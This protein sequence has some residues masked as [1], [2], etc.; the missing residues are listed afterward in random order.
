[1]HVKAFRVSNFRR[2][3]DVRVDLEADTSIFVGANNSGK[4]SAT[5][6]FQLFLGESKGSFSIYDFTADCWELFDSCDVDA[7]VDE[8]GLPVITFDLWFEVDE[9]NFHRVVDLLPSL[10]WDGS[11]V[12]V[13]MCY[14]PKDSSKLLQN[15]A[16][17]RNRAQL[18]DGD[19]GAYRPWP[20]TLT[21]YLSKRLRSE[22]EII[23]AVLDSA[24][25]GSDLKPA[26]GCQPF[27]LSNGA[28]VVDSL[29][30]VDFLDAQRHLSDAESRGRY[31]DLSKRLSRFYARNLS[32]HE[33]D[34]D[35]LRTLAESEMRLNAHFADVFDPLLASLAQLGYPGF[36]NHKLVVKAEINPG[37]VLSGN[38]HVH[39]ALPG[40]T[41]SKNADSGPTLPDQYNG[42][43]FKNLIYMVVEVLDFHHAWAGADGERPPVHLVMIEEPEA[44]LHAQLQ[45]VFIR[46]IQDVL[47]AA[48]DGFTTQMVV[49]THSAH[50]IYE[51]DFTP[52]R[53]FR[54]SIDASANHISDVRN[55][56][57]FYD[58]EEEATRDF[59][60]Q[61]LKLTHC[62]L[63]FADAA[64]LVEGNV[65]RLLLPLMIQKSRP[66]L[67][68]CHLTILEVGGAFAHKFQQLLS[69]LDLPTLIIT[70]L[71]SVESAEASDGDEDAATEDDVDDTVAAAGEAC[72]ADV[73]G[74]RTSNETL[75]QWVP[76]LQSVSELLAA[77]EKAKLA[78]DDQGQMG[79]VRVAY[80]TLQPASWGGVTE[81]V[82]GRTLEEAFALQN[83]EWSQHLDRR[84]LRLRI[85]GCDGLDLAALREKV[86]VRVRNLDKT[87]FAL[88]LMAQPSCEWTT[89]AYIS[90]GLDWL[91]D[92]V[93]TTEVPAVL[94]ELAPELK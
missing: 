3:K 63:F 48:D 46:K 41:D 84:P 20:Q 87:R 56:S 81:N 51:K 6:I 61:Y 88:E 39:Y 72:M 53:Y 9:L 93:K 29:I 22:Y 17:A 14:Q 33:D 50:I 44:H 43:G 15:F 13:R 8:N 85:R 86:F 4:T 5:H 64:V 94:P 71:D 38:A 70:D 77:D 68:A 47:P 90:E 58:D 45:Q 78:A 31:E 82:A 28:S 59:L 60:L 18:P 7:G 19:A 80:Q 76:K 75:I 35:A 10:D 37:A 25:C 21:E 30:R 1:M 69:F 66:E 27:P 67:R 36:N 23:Y 54:R 40:G 49:T 62:D 34:L 2:L 89:P 91:W 52:I 74:A 11:P 83:L 12:G 42:L 32:K 92:A 16:E 26:A 57:R 24:Q 55:L 73:A 79:R 65:E